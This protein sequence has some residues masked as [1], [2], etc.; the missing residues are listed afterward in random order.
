[1][2]YQDMNAKTID[3]WC[4]NGWQAAADSGSQ[5]FLLLV[6]NAP[7]WIIPVSNAGVKEKL[8]FHPLK[9]PKQY[10]DSIKNNWGIQFSHTL[11]EQIGGQIEAGFVLTDLYEDTNG[12]GKLHEYNIPSFLATRAIKK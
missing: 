11:E 7:C 12:E 8:P 3:S 4:E 1:M 6:Q 5:F 9:N 2:N 10:E